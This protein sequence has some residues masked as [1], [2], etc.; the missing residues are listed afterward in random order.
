[1]DAHNAYDVTSASNIHPG[2]SGEPFLQLSAPSYDQATG[3]LSQ[4]ETEELVFCESAGGSIVDELDP[5]SGECE[6]FVPS[7][8]KL[9]RTIAT[10]KGGLQ[11]RVTDRFESTDGKGHT[12]SL[13][14]GE[15]QAEGGSNAAS[16]KFPGESTFSAHSSGDT[17]PAGSSGPE[18]IYYQTDT[19]AA[20]PE[21]GLENPR[22]AITLSTVPDGVHFTREERPSRRT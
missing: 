3:D 15:E 8:V 14:Y 18:T 4:T 12:I 7:G 22:G 10:G 17:A 20:D 19:E 11:A 5:S 21:N 2:A 13:A 6:K 9:V 1:M 16:F